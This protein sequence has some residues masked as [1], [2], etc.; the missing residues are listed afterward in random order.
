MK[1][2]PKRLSLNKET[3]NKETLANLSANEM[4]QVKGQGFLSKWGKSCKPEKCTFIGSEV[5]PCTHSANGQTC[6]NCNPPD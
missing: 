3:L 2:Q 5:E 4:R 6:M 1:K